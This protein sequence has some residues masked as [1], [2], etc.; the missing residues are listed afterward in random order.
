MSNPTVSGVQVGM[1]ATQ[2]RVWNPGPC[3]PVVWLTAATT[4]TVT[5]G[6]THEG[7]RTE[8]V[9]RGGATRR[10][11]EAWSRGLSKG[12]A[13]PS[14]SVGQLIEDEPRGQVG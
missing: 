10:S 13:S 7:E 1:T 14:L 11:E 8:T 9:H 4:G 12:V 5:R 6:R 3:R 2:A